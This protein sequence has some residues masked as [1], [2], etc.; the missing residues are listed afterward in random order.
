M[1]S[2]KGLQAESLKTTLVDN[3]LII[4]LMQV[5]FVPFWFGN[6]VVETLLFFSLFVIFLVRV[7]IYKFNWKIVV[8]FF[9]HTTLALVQGFFWDYS[10]F[11]ILTSFSFLVLSAYFV[12]H[13]YGN[14]LFRIFDNFFFIF[15]IISFSFWVFINVSPL[16]KSIV[17][18][19]ILVFFPYSGD[20]WPRSMIIFT[21]WDQLD[22]YFLGLSRNSGF[23]HEPGGY[24]TLLVLMLCY[25]YVVN[26]G[27][28]NAKMVFYVVCLLSTFS[29]AGYISL[30]IVFLVFINKSKIIV[31][32]YLLSIV[33]V[34]SALFLYNT[35]DFLGEKV[36]E[37]VEDQYN[38]N[39]SETTT[40]RFLGF[41]KSLNVALNYPFYGRGINRVSMPNSRDDEEYLDYGW[42]GFAFKYGLI[43][44]LLFMFFFMKG[45]IS[46]FSRG[47]VG[48]FNALL[49]FVANLVN[50]S[51]Q[52]YIAKPLFFVFFLIGIN[53][54]SNE[55]EKPK[56]QLSSYN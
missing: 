31:V 50:L 20:E 29:T 1:H 37:Q 43:F 26:S 24:A 36:T 41:R 16:I 2:I 33:F 17:E 8:L 12:W 56:G 19:W 4:F 13:I 44:G 9:V 42:F 25:N 5:T 47:N 35:T 34:L 22:N 52:I 45:F 46:F 3:F 27:R 11:S 23:L 6:R 15:S 21:H 18:Q 49:F 10:V 51:S 30:F 7:G 40:G 39:L 38:K 55:L 48:W 53:I 32:R 14:K 54:S 28:F